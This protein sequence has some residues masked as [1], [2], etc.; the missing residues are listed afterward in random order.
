MS[1]P[2]TMKAMVLTGH[3]DLDMYQWHEDW[4][5][6]HPGPM[7][8]LIKV[9]AC[10]CNNTDINTRTAWYSDNIDDAFDLTRWR[11]PGNRTYEII[12]ITRN[13]RVSAQGTDFISL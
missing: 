11:N 8:V 10:G 5:T 9:G 12:G 13:N 2:E 7:E 3:G 1:I 6:P 4:P